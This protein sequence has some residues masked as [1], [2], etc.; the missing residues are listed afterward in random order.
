MNRRSFLAGLIAAPAIIKTPGLLMPVKPILKTF[1]LSANVSITYS[2]IL[3]WPLDAD[4]IMMGQSLYDSLMEE[5]ALEEAR[6]ESIFTDGH[7]SRI[8]GFDFIE[9]PV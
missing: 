4:V 9:R 2:E 3:E 6:Q 8:L 1:D 5:M 7:V